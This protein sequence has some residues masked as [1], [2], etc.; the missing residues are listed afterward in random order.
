MPKPVSDAVKELKVDK[1][2][3]DSV[4]KKLIATP[5]ISTAEVTAKIHGWRARPA[6]KAAPKLGSV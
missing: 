2:E 5:P 6:R 4:L 1:E 3:F